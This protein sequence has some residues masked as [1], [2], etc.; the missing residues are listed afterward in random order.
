MKHSLQNLSSF[1]LSLIFSSVNAG[2]QITFPN[3][4][5]S[6]SY[7]I[8]PIKN[9]LCKAVKGSKFLFNSL[10][11]IILLTG[12]MWSGKSTELIRRIDR[13]KYAGQKTTLYKYSKDTRYGRTFMVSS[14][15]GLHRDA[16]PITTLK[17]VEFEPG[18]VIGIDE[19]QFIDH[20]VEFAESAANAG[21]TVIISALN[22]DFE[23][24]AFERIVEIIPKCEEIVTFHAIC[25][26][27]K[28]EASFTRRI[29]ESKEVEVIGG[30]D[31]YKAVCRACYYQ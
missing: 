27:C 9:G 15:G 20:L 3:G 8:N 21:C 10:K 13:A 22:S 29:T 7:S 28:K 25:F 6:D 2:S 4:S 14:H 5:Y 18:S 30:S 1:I 19:G 24:N 12:G 23:R 17:G 26:D 11:M 31:K 16:I